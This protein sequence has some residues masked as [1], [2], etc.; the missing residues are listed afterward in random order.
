M[1]QNAEECH[2]L[3]AK[4]LSALLITSKH[5]SDFYCL[6]FLHSFSIENNWEYHKKVCQNKGFCNVAVPSEDTK[7]LEFNK[8]QKSDKT[9]FIVHGDLQCLIEKIDGCKNNPKSSSTS[10][11]DQHIPSSFSMST[12]FPSKSIENKHDE[13]RGKDCM[14]D[15]CESLTEH[16]L[17]MINF[18]K[19]KMKL[20]AKK[21]QKSYGNAKNCYTC[22]EKLENKY[23]KD[24]KHRKFS[25]HYHYTGKY[26][27]AV[28]NI[29]NLKYSALEKFL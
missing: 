10:K 16:A 25:D 3:A 21:Q 17:K 5:H 1:I 9:P 11:V 12:I 20:L 7:I 23:L 24:K 18:K 15:F 6:N 26:G 22:N 27:G 29:G 14:K 8:I 4:Q 28:H 19:K 13:Y 2:F